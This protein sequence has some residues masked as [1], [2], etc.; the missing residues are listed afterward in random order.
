M[1]DALQH[2]CCSWTCVAV[3]NQ[4][5][6][7]GAYGQQYMPPAPQQDDDDELFGQVRRGHVCQFMYTLCSAASNMGCLSAHVQA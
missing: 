6:F 1:Q 5:V 4:N 7:T 2:C 3:L